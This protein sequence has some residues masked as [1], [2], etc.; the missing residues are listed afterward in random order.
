[1][2]TEHDLGQLEWTVAGWTPY[3]WQQQRSI[4]S[5]VSLNAEIPA[6]PATVPGSVQGAL[7]AAGLLPDWNIGVQAR[8]CEWVEN[9]HWV[10]TAHIPDDWLASAPIVRLHALGMDYKG[11]IL[12]NGKHVAEFEGSF[13]PHIV[14]LTA[15]L[16]ERDNTL[17][18]VF[19]SGPRW[20]GQIGYTSQMREWKPRFN[21][22]WDWTSRLVQTG[23]WDDLLLEVTD[24]EELT[25]LDCRS[26]A[27]PETGR[28]TL[29]LA[30]AISGDRG[31][32]VRITLQREGRPVRVEEVTPQRL[33]AGVQWSDLPVELWW[34][35][36]REDQPLYD[37]SVQLLDVA[38]QICDEASR[39][40]GFVSIEWQPCEGAPPQAD[41]WVCVINGRPTFLQGVNWTP[42]LPNFADVSDD[43]YRHL[44]QT[45]RDLGCNMLRVWGGAFLEK[46]IFY[47][48][49]DELGLL[50]WQEFP[51]SS[52]GLDNRAP[53]DPEAVEQMAAIG[54]SYVKRRRHHVSLAVWC[55]GNELQDDRPSDLS[56]PMLARLSEVVAAHDPGRRYLATS[57]SGPSFSTDEANVGKGLHWDVH[58]PWKPE[59]DVNG[60][61]TRHWEQNDALFHSEIGAP[62]ASS[63]EI[64]RTYRG[65][66]PEVPGTH[67]NPLWRRTSWWIE[68]PEFVRECGREPADLEEYVAWSQERQQ[69][70]LAIAAGS[71]K[72]RFPRCGGFLIWMGH[73]C[74]P[75]TANTS[76][77][78]FQGN[79]KPA[80]LAV[81][82]IYRED[83]K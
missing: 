78:D 15:H 29:Q 55:G 68:W 38:G 19:D 73:D 2:R 75:C 61:W 43:Q 37:L 49:C 28:G 41:P 17:Q 26:T 58:G 77:I 6:I 71:T 64:I 7:R 27:D 83:T 51:L 33:Q 59:G 11:W 30:E 3:V 67:A 65:D 74:F 21:Y 8:L 13:V 46:E 45:Y 53:D 4:E 52:S 16:R 42:I 44:L 22:F 80:A 47:S 34:P 70:A 31:A 10:Y 18:I 60:E 72:A 57:P 5:G 36:G 50:V 39:R 82:K 63:A 24:G 20:L 48:L 66:L 79:P 23:I 1:M 14:D 32:S 9:R 56:H 25:Q 40:I 76:I 35:N 54:E 62:S 69:Q 12:V 81:G